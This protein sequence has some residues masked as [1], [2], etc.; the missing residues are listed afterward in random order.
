MGA[1]YYG[2]YS[3]VQA[4]IGGYSFNVHKHL[5]TGEGGMIITNNRILANRCR[6]LRNHGENLIINKDKKLMK[7]MIGYNFRMTEI[8]AAIGLAQLKKLKLTINKKK[9][10]KKISNGLKNLKD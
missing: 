5:N 1:K 3:G 9:I 10:A 6:K 7:N 2:K 8:D 4:D